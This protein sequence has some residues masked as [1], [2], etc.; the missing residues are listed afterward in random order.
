MAES[1]KLLKE[2][3]EM[4]FTEYWF[5]ATEVTLNAF[6]PKAKRLKNYVLLNYK[7]QRRLKNQ[8]PVSI[9]MLRKSFIRAQDRNK[10]LDL[11]YKIVTTTTNQFDKSKCPIFV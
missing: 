3:Q 10:A 8:N 7:C 9:K 2:L 6:L 11:H 1:K 4:L 5:L